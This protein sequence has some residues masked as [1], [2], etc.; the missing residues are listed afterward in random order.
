MPKKSFRVLE[1][2]CGTGLVGSRVLLKAGI[3]NSMQS[4]WAIEFAKE[5]PNASVV[6][7]DL[8]PIQPLDV[9]HNCTFRVGN[10][11]DESDW[12][13]LGMFDFIHSRAMLSAFRSWPK[14]ME[15]AFK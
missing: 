8:S 15:R 6:G 2:G 9:P 5:H 13:D 12:L 11:E 7:I 4:Q 10:V 14:F 1:L 3:N